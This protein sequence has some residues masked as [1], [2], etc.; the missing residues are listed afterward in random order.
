[1]ASNSSTALWTSKCF[2]PLQL[3]RKT[4]P[5]QSEINPLFLA[6]N[7]VELFLLA[8]IR[9]IASWTI[10]MPTSPKS[11]G[12][13]LVVALGTPLTL[14]YYWL[15]SAVADSPSAT[16]ASVG[17]NS[18]GHGKCRHRCSVRQRSPWPLVMFN[19]PAFPDRLSS[20]L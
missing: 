20:P 14:R 6:P 15:D 19:G 5:H 9:T 8:F 12:A 16:S 2:K 11:I 1:M 4:F 10:F 3:I 7:F 13:N 17:E 18:N